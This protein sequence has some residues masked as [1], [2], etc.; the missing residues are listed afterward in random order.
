[1][2]GAEAEGYWM[3]GKGVDLYVGGVE[4]AV[5]H[6][7]YA[8]FWHKVLHDLG[9]VS[10]P[11]P[12]GKL[13]NQ[14]YIQAYAFRD[15]RGMYVPAEEVESR[16]EGYYYEGRP[17]TREYGKMGKSLKNMVTPDDVISTQGCD[18]LRLYEM[19]MGPLDKSK[20]WSTDDIVGIRR[21]LN[22][23][24]RNFVAEEPPAADGSPGAERSRIVEAPASDALRR[25]LHATIAKVSE[26]YEA[27]S[28]NTAIAALIELNNALVKSEV[29]PREVAEPFALML[30]PMAPH[31]AEELWQRLGHTTSVTRADWPTFDPALLVVEEV[32][33]ALQVNGKVRGRLMV[34][35]GA[36]R[37]EIQTQAMADEGVLRHLEGKTVRKV[38]VVP[39]RLINIVAT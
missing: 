32:E 8:R 19:Y 34:P 9:H 14:G 11:E 7:L 25:L 36:S 33:L 38:I 16:D 21:F 1:M 22:R 13:F 24:W 17:V 10:T 37:E 26:D 15:A 20:P 28:F 3:G 39:D 31:L 30:A 5:L 2:V 23:V 6:L 12:F 35:A 18:T 27:M 29:L 4:H